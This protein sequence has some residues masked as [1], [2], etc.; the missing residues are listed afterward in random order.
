MLA[1]A[2]GG[3]EAAR[4]ACEDGKGR[5]K[6]E[7]E[8][9]M[10]PVGKQNGGQNRQEGGRR[11]RNTS[12]DQSSF[13]ME[14]SMLARLG[15]AILLLPSADR[16]KARQRP[17][18]KQD[19]R[20]GRTV[21]L[22]ATPSGPSWSILRSRLEGFGASLACVEARS[23]GLRQRRGGRGPYA[24]VG[25][26]ARRRAGGRQRRLESCRLGGRRRAAASAIR[27]R[28]GPAGLWPERRVELLGV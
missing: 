20:S 8:V 13:T 7:A 11:E 12:P 6:G 17:K 25:W 21:E 3:A 14:S 16:S 19:R 28:N 22:D 26:R 4:W 9:Q 5:M 10:H 1:A 23:S 18:R 2:V 15:A 24:Q 27:L